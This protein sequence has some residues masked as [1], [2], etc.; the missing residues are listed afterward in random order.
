VLGSR[1]GA[2]SN[3]KLKRLIFVALVLA[4]AGILAVWWKQQTPTAVPASLKVKETELAPIDRQ[5]VLPT[6]E[7]KARPLRALWISYEGLGTPCAD[8]LGLRCLELADGSWQALA[9]LNRPVLISLVNEF[10]EKSYAL[11]H[12]V[13]LIEGQVRSIE[14]LS[15]E[16]VIPVDVRRLGALW[17]GSY[18]FLWTPPL[19][20]DQALARGVKSPVVTQV[21]LD[22]AKL[23]G[24][25]RPLAQNEFNR[26]LHERVVAFQAQ[27][28][29]ST[30]GVVGRETLIALEA[31][32]NSAPGVAA[33]VAA[34]EAD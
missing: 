9:A 7:S 31:E 16:G 4:A 11:V 13:N 27:N 14:L 17:D 12:R 32:L 22:F 10:R 23:D 15:P 21:A 30:D 34:L 29:L 6:F 19:G 26:L 33:I 28:G 24:A 8:E 3:A 2:S 1:V 25:P 5:S 18:L 20:F